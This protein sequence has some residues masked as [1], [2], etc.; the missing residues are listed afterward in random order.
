VSRTDADYL[1][2]DPFEGDRDVNVKCRTVKMVTTRRPQDCM[3]PEDGKL[4]PIEPGTRA[5][6]E[7]ALIDG[8]FWGKYYVCVAC[9]DK[10]LDQWEPRAVHAASS[11]GEKR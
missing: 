5:R 6:F 1:R 11:A 10:W 9:M 3:D 8:D 2:Y 7:K 4:H